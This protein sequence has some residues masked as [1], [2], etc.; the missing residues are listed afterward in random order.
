MAAGGRLICHSGDLLEAGRGVRFSVVWRGREEPAFAV[1]F[2][3]RVYAYL[4][5]C[6]HTPIEL[7]WNAGEFFDAEGECLIRPHLGKG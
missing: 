4:N 2:R 1:R 7:D 3:G 6:A 5:R